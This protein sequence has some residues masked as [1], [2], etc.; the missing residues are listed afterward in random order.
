MIPDEITGW[1]QTANETFTVSFESDYGETYE[2]DIRLNSLG[3]HDDVTLERPE[4]T[5]R[6][7][8]MGDS[9]VNCGQTVFERCAQGRIEELLDPITAQDV[10]VMTAGISGWGTDQEWLF[11]KNIGINYDPQIVLLVMY[12]G[13]D[14]ANNSFN[15]DPNY[16]WANGI[17]GKKYFHL[18]EDGTLYQ[19]DYPGITPPAD[20][21]RDPATALEQNSYLYRLIMDSLGIWSNL[22]RSH[23]GWTFVEKYGLYYPLPHDW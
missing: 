15:L 1:K 5:L 7:L 14:I 23:T 11:Y 9:F 17:D 21:L 12:M 6:I 8:Y 3:F 22:R 19:Q 20:L 10:E 4:N 2:H 13:N 18:A 16:R